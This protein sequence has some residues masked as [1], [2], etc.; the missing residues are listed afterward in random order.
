MIQ[1]CK[2]QP[3]SV[4]VRISLDV[5]RMWHFSV[6]IYKGHKTYSCD[7]CATTRQHA[8]QLADEFASMILNPT[9]ACNG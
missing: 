8:E 7:G 4:Q 9:E 2:A 3:N 1:C 6:E 5:E